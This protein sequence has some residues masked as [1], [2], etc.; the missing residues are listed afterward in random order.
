LANVL[1]VRNF[2]DLLDFWSFVQLQIVPN[3]SAL[4]YPLE[5]NDTFQIRTCILTAL[6]DK[7]LLPILKTHELNID[8]RVRIRPILALVCFATADHTKK[9]QEFVELSDRILFN[10]SASNECSED[11]RSVKVGYTIT[12]KVYNLFKVINFILNN[13]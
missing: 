6:R 10:N 12:L 5:D 4:V 11:L 2:N 7:V 13:L 1:A 9:H 3:F 8:E